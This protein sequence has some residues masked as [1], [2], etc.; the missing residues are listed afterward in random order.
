[1]DITTTETTGSP[2]ELEFEIRDHNCL[3]VHASAVT[4]CRVQLEHMVDRSD[5]RLL[6]FFTVEGTPPDRVLSMAEASSAI[7]EARLVSRGPDGGLFEFVVSGPC[8]TRTLADTGAIARSVSAESG[9]GAVLADVP[10]HIEVRRVVERFRDRHPNSEL[11]AC[12]DTAEPIPVRSERGVH[13]ML[14][15]RLTDKQ[16]EVLRTAYLSGY[17]S[18]PRRTTAE[19]CAEALGISQPTFSQHI[20]TAQEKLLDRLFVDAPER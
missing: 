8:V 15:D 17:F 2:V 11:L 14:A 16:H 19:E 4:D 7:D 5:D 12:R 10:G 20:R 6:E 1:M 13:A 3:F 18:W 9:V